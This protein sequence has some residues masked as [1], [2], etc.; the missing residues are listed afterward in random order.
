MKFNLFALTLLV[1][2]GL[3]SCNK[4]VPVGN[5]ENGKIVLSF[6]DNSVD[7]WFR[8]LPLLDSL[9]IRATFY[10]SAY[11]KLS[12]NQKRKLKTI[13]AHGHEIAYHTTNHRDL[14]KLYTSYSMHTMLAEEIQPDLVMMRKDGFACENFAYPYGQHDY[15]LDR[16][17][18]VYFK[19]VRAVSRPKTIN[20][21]YTATT[22]C[23]QILHARSID[24]DCKINDTEIEDMVK[25]AGE[26]KC[27][28]LFYG[29]EINNPAYKR[30]VPARVLRFLAATAKKYGLSFVTT[31]AIIR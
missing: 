7:N 26:K 6:D 31:N 18:L 22:G 1:L 10:I 12:E 24:N 20:T 8:Y 23:N 25:T 21:S 28:V 16:Q 3:W 14:E 5:M 19:S 4:E 27:A 13:S 15:L 9:G 2:T 11:H 17:L 29:H 30:N